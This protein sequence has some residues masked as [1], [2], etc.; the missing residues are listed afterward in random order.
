LAFL[1]DKPVRQEKRQARKHMGQVRRIE[2]LI[3]T[4]EDRIDPAC[5]LLTTRFAFDPNTE[6]VE[7]YPRTLTP[8]MAAPLFCVP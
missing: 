8:Q 3:L 7:V 2:P 5:D 6:P 1:L 4:A